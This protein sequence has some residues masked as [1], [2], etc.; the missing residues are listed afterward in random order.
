[1][2]KQVAAFSSM[3][4]LSFLLHSNPLVAQQLDAAVTVNYEAVSASNKDLLQG[5][6]GDVR[7]YLNDYTWGSDNQDVKV[8]CTFDIRIQ[9]VV[10]DNRYGAQL[11][12]GSKRKLYGSGRKSVVIRILDD[13]WEFTYVRNRPIN[14]NSYSFNDLASLL[15]FY[16][17]III[18]YDFDSYDKLSGT[19]YFQ[20]AADIASLGRSIGQKGWVPAKS[21]YSRAQFIDELT[22]TKFA[23]LR[24]ASYVYH[25]TGLDSLSFVD[26]VT[27]NPERAWS[28]ILKALDMYAKARSY[29][30]ARNIMIR[31]F[32]E[33]KYMELADTFLKYP[34][35]RVYIKLSNIDP[36]HQTTYEEYRTKKRGN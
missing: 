31:S 3:M 18:G 33:T 29:A 10:G 4:V 23:P 14:H 17:Y 25:F 34:D 8:E 20:K 6:E 27:G 16:A 11:F 13:A 15:D 9:N 12:V 21:G 28:N 19:P 5:F 22:D 30:D 26:P 36:S 32:F 2:S 35:E 24:V 1:M 7:A